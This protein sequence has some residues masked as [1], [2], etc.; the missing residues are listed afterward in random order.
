MRHQV[1]WLT[2]IIVAVTV[3][4]T[5]AGAQQFPAATG[6]S[7]PA[8]LERK[9]ATLEA[10]L[11]V[12]TW[13]AQTQPGADT[14]KLARYAQRQ[15]NELFASGI[16]ALLAEDG[17]LWAKDD[18]RKLT[19]LRHRSPWPLPADPGMRDN[20][21][22]LITD[23]R[24]SAA[25]AALCIEDGPCLDAT[26]VD[27]HISLGR[28]PAESRFYWDGWRRQLAPQRPLYSRLVNP[29]NAAA[30]EWGY[31][32]VV[33]WR[34]AG[35]AADGAG[36]AATTEQLWQQMKP[37]YGALH[38]HVA[39][40]IGA[41]EAAVA[42]ATDGMIPARS[43]GRLDPRDWRR[44]VAPAAA[45]LPAPLSL[46]QS[47]PQ[48]FSSIQEL[49]HIAAAFFGTLGYPALPDSFWQRSRFYDSAEDPACSRAGWAIDGYRDTRIVT[50]NEI[51]EANFRWLHRTIASL[52]Y[53]LAFA[54]LD[55]SYRTPPHP[56]LAD[57]HAQLVLLSLT[58]IY[59]S[60]L[61]LLQ[62]LPEEDSEIARLLNQSLQLLPRLMINIAAAQWRRSVFLRATEQADYNQAWWR[63]MRRYAGI[64]AGPQRSDGFDPALVAEIIN[65]QD[66]L[67]EVFGAVLGYQLLAA[68]C[69]EAS[70]ALHQCSIAGN[71]TFGAR[72]HAMLRLG[73][74]KPWPEAL[75]QVTGSRE[76]S[77]A[78]LLEYYAPLQRWLDQQNAARICAWQAPRGR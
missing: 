28:D 44:W 17:G 29:L 73:A 45:S 52:H 32:N 24:R 12:T 53:D 4:P 5:I 37:L 58:P 19:L 41:D 6:P 71:K 33:E 47:V 11:G 50:C 40:Q 1:V 63:L 16:A 25:M 48:R 13:L 15:R 38:C 34:A 23:L 9:L 55:W 70:V 2:A 75:E 8:Q 51:G 60:G 36:L 30:A 20:L 68:A 74:S 69:A 77:A 67:A 35:Y 54:D 72:L 3:L 65:Q 78:S 57:A 43:L 21:A 76:I 18:Q 10:D 66:L 49:A 31:A 62:Q 56:G 22:K 7:T 27:E 26:G 39:A 46:Q 42:H 61:G 14:I 64:D 59:L